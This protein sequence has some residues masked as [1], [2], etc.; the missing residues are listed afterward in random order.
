M[1]CNP[2]HTNLPLLSKIESKCFDQ[3]R[4]DKNL[5]K[6]MNEELDQMEKNDTRELVSI[7]K[8][9]NT[10]ATKWRFRN[11]LNEYGK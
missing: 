1:I 10:I 5:V 11:K 4:K 6:V 8:D 9:K 2:P 7:P 3:A